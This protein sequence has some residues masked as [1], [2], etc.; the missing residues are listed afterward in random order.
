MTSSPPGIGDG[1]RHFWTAV[2]LLWLAGLGLRLTVLAVPPVI[3]AVQA[4]LGLS[5]TEVGILSGLPP[6]LFAVAALPGSLL[7]ARFGAL[8]TLVTGFVVAGVASGLRGA[9][10]DTAVLY[11]FTI[12]MGAGIAVTQ[13]AL[14]L[15]VRQ[16]LP[17]R[18]SFGAAVY[19]NGLLVS[20]TL[21]VMLT[22]PVLLPLLAGSWQWSFVAWGAPLVVIAL[23]IAVLAPAS[24]RTRTAALTG[25]PRWWPDWRDP[26]IWKLGLVFGA[27]NSVYF[28][29]NTFLPGHLTDGGR[30]DLIAP[31]LTALNFCQLPSSLVLLAVAGRLERRAWPLVACGVVTIASVIG[32][33]VT[34]SVWTVIFAGLFG[35]IAAVIMTLG[36][37]LPALLAPPAEVARLSAAM[38]TISYSEA[39]VVSVLGGVAWDLGGSARYAFFPIALAALPLILV[40][41]TIRIGRVGPA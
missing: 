15:L 5:G 9:W 21:P 34:A 40:P 22:I 11:L 24:E 10:P 29:C 2:S 41:G 35:A 23:V 32:I 38:F 27:V 6:I 7:V 12:A 28:G 14:P 20:E 30:P 4:D 3:L 1:A 33:L 36:F 16:W 17:R 37:A 19:T 39:L 18:L 26:L 25:A 31:A 13:P 8:A